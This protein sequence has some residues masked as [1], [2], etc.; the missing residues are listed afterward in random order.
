[1]FLQFSIKIWTVF[2]WNSGFSYRYGEFF[3]SVND[4]FQD[5]RESGS[6]PIS[7]FPVRRAEIESTRSRRNRS[8]ARPNSVSKRGTQILCTIIR[9]RIAEFVRNIAATG[10]KILRCAKFFDLRIPFFDVAQTGAVVS[11][12]TLK[13]VRTTLN[14][15]DCIRELSFLISARASTWIG[16]RRFG[17]H[18]P[19]FVE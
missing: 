7:E 6:K 9:V 18:E 2:F 15:L 5:G 14:I 3:M 19:Q 13:F 11:R 8:S 10:P 17:E 4:R 1:M 12:R 16:I